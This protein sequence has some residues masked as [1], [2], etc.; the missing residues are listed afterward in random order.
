M[1]EGTT[2]NH[3]FIYQPL[4]KWETRL[5]VLQSAISSSSELRVELVC[6]NLLAKPKFEALS[7]TWGDTSARK[8]M[9]LCK[10]RFLVLEN[11]SAALLSL[12]HIMKDRVLWVDALCINQQD[13]DERRQQVQQM[14]ATP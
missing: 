2:D 4:K 8:R 9:T 5:L 6:S 14:R 1:M 12:R 7:Y 3:A 11:L 13:L 10:R